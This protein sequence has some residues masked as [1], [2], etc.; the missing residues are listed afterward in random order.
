MQEMKTYESGIITCGRK[1]QVQQ[2]IRIERNSLSSG[3]LVC[4]DQG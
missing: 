4:F 3:L 2:K 1:M